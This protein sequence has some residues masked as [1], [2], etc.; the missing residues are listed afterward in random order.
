MEGARVPVPL[1]SSLGED[2]VFL[3]QTP[4]PR[5]LTSHGDSCSRKHISS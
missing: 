3:V 2:G 4:E 5:Q 1:I